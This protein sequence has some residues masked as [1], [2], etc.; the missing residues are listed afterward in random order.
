MQTSTVGTVNLDNRYIRSFQVEDGDGTE[1]TINQANEWKFVE[2]S[3]TGASIDINWSDTSNGSDADPYDLTFTVTNTDRGST[4]V[5]PLRIFKNVVSDSGTA[6]ADNTADTLSILG[7]TNI[8]TAVVGDTLTINNEYTYTHPTYAGDDFSIDTGPLTGATVISDL[9]INVTTDTLGHVTDANG[10]VAT[11]DLTLSDLGFLG[12]DVEVNG[13]HVAN[14]GNNHDVDFKNGN[15]TTAVW[16]ASGNRIQWNHNTFTSGGTFKGGANNGIVIEDFYIDSYGHVRSV[17]TVDLDGRYDN[18]NEW[19][20][21][22]NGD[23]TNY[24]HVDSTE[25]VKFINGTNTTTERGGTGTVSDPHTIKVNFVNPGYISSQRSA[26]FDAVQ[27]SG[28]NNNPFL[29]MTD[30]SNHDV[31]IVGGTNV[32]VTRDNNHQITI[33]ANDTDVDVTDANLRARLAGLHKDNGGTVFIGDSGNDLDLRIRGN[34]RVEGTQTIMNTETVTTHDNKIELNSNAASTPTEDAG[35][36]V[37]RGSSTNAQIY[38]SEANDRWYHTYGDGGTAYVIP[39]PSESMSQ[40]TIHDGDGTQ[41]TIA[42]SKEIKFQ[43]GT[44]SAVRSGDD[45]IQINWTDTSTGS[46]TDPYD[47]TFAH[48]L[49]TRSDP[50]VG[51]TSLNHS[52]S[53]SAVTGV[54]T[55]ATGHLT[56]VNTTQFTLPAGAVPNNGLLDI[57]AGSLIDLTIT[58]GDFTADKST[59]TDITINVDL[60]ELPDMGDSTNVVGTLDYMLVLDN[61]SA[62]KKKK[63]STVTLSD[64]NNDEGWTSNTGDITRVNITAGVG[65]LGSVNTASGDHVQTIKANL[66][67]ETLR[68]V[69][70]QSITTTA[71]RTYAVMP[72]ADGDL[73][74]NVPWQDN[75]DNQ[76]TTF[77]VEDGDSTDVTIGH[78]KHWKFVEGSEDVTASGND[79]IQI[80]WTDTSTGSSSDQYDLSFSHKR[81]SRSNTTNNSATTSFGGNFTIV[82]SVTTNATGHVTGVNTKTITMPANPNSNTFL[83]DVTAITDN[84]T[85]IKLVHTM[86]SGATHDIVIEAGSG[87]TLTDNANND[88]AFEISV[89][90]SNLDF[91]KYTSW[92]FMEGNGTETGVITSEDTL[93]FEQGGITTVEKTADDQ[94]TIS[95]PGTDLATAYSTSGVTITSS[96]G[97]N[98]AITEASGTQAGVMTVAHHDKLDGIDP[99]ADVNQNSYLTI[100]AYRTAT[101]NLISAGNPYGSSTTYV[102]SSATSVN[103]SISFF[104]GPG[105]D[106]RGGHISSTATNEIQWD[107]DSDQRSVIKQIG[108][109]GT[110][111]MTINAH[112]TGYIYFDSHSGA[113]DTTGTHQL[114]F[115]AGGQIDAH[116]NIVA[117]STATSS[118]RKLKENIQKVEGALELVSQLDGVTF[119]WKDK[120]RG[121]AAGVIAQNVEEVLPSAVKDVDTLSEEG[122]THKVVDYNQLSALFIEAIKELK[123]E[124][125]LLR[126]EIESLK[127]INN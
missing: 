100:N 7:G 113:S 109:I 117:F 87:I 88:Y 94:L 92:T 4:A 89:D 63:I 74:V 28:S 114:R 33:A 32:T 69:T 15:H 97:N 23:G 118:D 72:D 104:S 60:L 86:S 22:D 52:A 11:R 12:W 31:K 54:S 106:I 46:D 105:I 20:L 110:G 47:L 18:Y 91:D 79:Y 102:P 49:T 44:T 82:D 56:A 13:T 126:A 62:Q 95:T 5:A 67:S 1:V 45:Y 78:D 125:K 98:A 37:N 14:I 26:T 48:K 77:V 112:G 122:E 81:T 9:D 66:I 80:N 27:N 107:L 6:V 25:Y 103:D 10:V 41:R 123:E 43:E 55:N 34:L 2:G 73:V 68:S 64:F 21:Q 19:R 84:T 58:G 16:T 116:G 85:D 96:T 75:N 127:D 36:I 61:N 99:G 3:G 59:E 108:T 53:F 93:H 83:N 17:G 121:S 119:D 90:E 30:A 115:S 111:N 38:W 40:F 70:A 29:R 57:N 39:L 65:L 101:S 24:G 124:N 51:S 42:D 76:L 50:A 35:L 120:E 71:N 8:N